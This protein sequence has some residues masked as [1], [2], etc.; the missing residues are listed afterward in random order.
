[1]RRKN[2]A[3]ISARRS[4]APNTHRDCH[5]PGDTLHCG[6]E[7]ATHDNDEA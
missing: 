3:L 4:D 5:A 2:V 1:M 6:D 7:A